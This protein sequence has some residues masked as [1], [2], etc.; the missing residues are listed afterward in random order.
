M[1][2]IIQTLTNN[3]GAQMKRVFCDHRIS[4]W[5]QGNIFVGTDYNLRPKKTDFNES[6]RNNQFETLEAAKSF[7]NDVFDLVNQ[8]LEGC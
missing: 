7:T 5:Q 1:F 3:T 2:V 4:V 6:N 8:I